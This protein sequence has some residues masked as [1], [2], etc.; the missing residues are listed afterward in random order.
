MWFGLNGRR[1]ANLIIGDDRKGCSVAP[2][3]TRV[4]VPPPGSVSCSVLGRRIGCE[5][6]LDGI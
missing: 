1:W 2:D 6:G 3:T 5:S 4:D